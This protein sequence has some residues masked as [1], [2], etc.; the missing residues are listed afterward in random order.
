M[1]HAKTC[2]WWSLVVVGYGLAPYDPSKLVSP[3]LVR[4][5]DPSWV[6]R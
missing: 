4:S 2:W 3:V 5:A 1:N 6:V